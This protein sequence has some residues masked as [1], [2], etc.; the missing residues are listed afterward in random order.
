[1]SISRNKTLVLCGQTGT[2]KSGLAIELAQHFN[3]EVISADSRQVY[4]GL[5]IN[6][7]KIGAHEMNGIPHHMLDVVDLHH[8]FSVVEYVEQAQKVIANIHS[9]GKLAI[10]CGGTGQYI[11]ALTMPT[12]FPA[13]PANPILR[14]ELEQIIPSELFDILKERDPVRAENIDPNNK[15]RLVRA[16]EIIETLGSVPPLTT[17]DSTNNEFLMIGLAMPKDELVERI[18]IRIDNSLNNMIREVEQLHNELHIPW[19]R[20]HRLGLW[21]DLVAQHVQGNL[22][23]DELIEKMNTETWQYAKRQKTWFQ[24]D[25][26]IQWFHPVSDM[27]KILDAVAD[28]L[29]LHS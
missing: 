16:L 8:D 10:V 6:S 19:P 12:S 14:A 23:R 1:M 22:S 24:R 13:V 29:S 17:T 15:V 25:T 11:N 28:F 4:S 20:L 26:R 27:E 2:G 3:G 21:P 9:R 18:R 5:D 7:G